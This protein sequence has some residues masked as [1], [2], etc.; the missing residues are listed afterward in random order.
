VPTTV[1]STTSSTLA[2]IPNGPTPPSTL[3]LQSKQTS[4]HVSPVFPV[5]SGIGAAVVAAMLALQWFLTRPG[6]KGWTL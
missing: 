5:L 6:R 4:A 2:S 1:S 3:P